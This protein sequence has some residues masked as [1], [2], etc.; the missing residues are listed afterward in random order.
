MS[1]FMKAQFLVLFA[2]V[3]GAMVFVQ[4][5]YAK[6]TVIPVEFR[7]KAYDPI[8]QALA[9]QAIEYFQKDK[10]FQVAATDQPKLVVHM[11][12]MGYDGKDKVSAYSIVIAFDLP[13]NNYQ[14][15]A[16]ST[17]GVCTMKEVPDDAKGIWYNTTKLIE[18]FP[19]LVDT[20]K[21]T[22]DK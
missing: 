19:M 14:T 17:V 3:L 22:K 18:N 8:G 12:T 13:G 11:S 2:V 15:L 9:Q 20:V 6:S 16:G 10:Q 7:V 4:P 5:V 21:I 1:K